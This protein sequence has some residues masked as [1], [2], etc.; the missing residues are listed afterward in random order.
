[1]PLTEKS[2]PLFLPGAQ[3]TRLGAG[4]C[5]RKERVLRGEPEGE[6]RGREKVEQEHQWWLQLGVVVVVVAPGKS[7]VKPCAFLCCAP[8]FVHQ[9]QLPPP[10]GAHI[11][12]S[13]WVILL[14][15][16]SSGGGSATVVVAGCLLF[17]Y[18]T[19]LRL[20]RSCCPDG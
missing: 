16:Q 6:P 4:V 12:G 10:K 15:H 8:V 3:E 17:V 9:Q 7:P 11:L 19:L 5:P 18:G 20:G 13:G 1:M 14:L 2:V